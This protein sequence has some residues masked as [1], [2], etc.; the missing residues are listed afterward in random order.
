MLKDDLEKIEY[1]NI[2]HKIRYK[3]IY[4]T[5]QTKL[6]DGNLEATNAIIKILKKCKQ[7]NDVLT[8]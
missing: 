2:H 6:L 1:Q 3:I 8:R 7:N 5:E 4:L